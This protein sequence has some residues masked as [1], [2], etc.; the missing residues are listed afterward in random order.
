VQLAFDLDWTPSGMTVQSSDV[1]ITG[2]GV[3]VC[4]QYDG[5]IEYRMKHT[6][7]RGWDKL[8]FSNGFLAWI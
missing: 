4:A 2:Q 8:L 1:A 7:Q 6:G 5:Q 3:L